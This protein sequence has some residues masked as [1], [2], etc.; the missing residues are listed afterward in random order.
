R[1]RVTLH[2]AVSFSDGTPLDAASVQASLGRLLDPA[3]AAPGRFGV[4]AIAS[5]EAV[6]DRTRDTLNADAL[7]PLL[8][9]P[10]HPVT[11]IVPVSHGDAL[12]RQPVG[13]GPY[14]FESW[15]QGDSVVLAANADYW[16]GAPAIERVVF[17]VIPEVSTQIVELRSGGLDVLF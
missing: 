14:V 16:G 2:E 12:A 13:S 7:A 3:T 17:R 11:A 1:L 10:A 15:T 5:V 4:S 6:D 9:D 8:A